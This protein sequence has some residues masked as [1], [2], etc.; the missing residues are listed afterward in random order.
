MFLQTL[1]DMGLLCIYLFLYILVFFVTFLLKGFQ[2]LQDKTAVK[3]F[4]LVLQI[5][6]HR[7][8]KTII[9]KFINKITIKTESKNKNKNLTSLKL[10]FEVK[11]YHEIKLISVHF[12]KRISAFYHDIYNIFY[13]YYILKHLDII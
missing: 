1:R 7:I 2:F 10:K 4:P 12:M 5:F 6:W 9:N 13:Y 3:F 8:N 11:V